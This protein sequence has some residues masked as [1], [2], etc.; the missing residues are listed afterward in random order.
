MI[1]P[2]TFA[3]AQNMTWVKTLLDDNFDAPWKCIEFVSFWKN[4]IKMLNICG[5]LMVQRVF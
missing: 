5:N 1:D 3:T 2:L 4:L